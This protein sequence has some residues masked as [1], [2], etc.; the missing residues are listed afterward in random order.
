VLLHLQLSADL[1]M[2]AVHLLQLCVRKCTS[3]EKRIQQHTECLIS[4]LETVACVHSGKSKLF[5]TTAD[6]KHN[7]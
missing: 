2:L 6:L 3:S 5:S 1:V 7:S 4:C